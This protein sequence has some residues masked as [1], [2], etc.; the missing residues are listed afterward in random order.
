MKPYHATTP[1][2]GQHWPEQNGIY[3]GIARGFD[4]EPDGH[5]VLLDDMPPKKRMTWKRGMAWAVGLGNGAR[6]P[7]QFE[8]ALI[9][10]NIND[11][12]NPEGFYWSASEYSADSAWNQYLNSSYTSDQNGSVKTNACYVRAIR[13][14][15]VC[16]YDQQAMEL[17]EVCGWKAKMDG[18]PC[19][20]CQAPQIDKLQAAAQLG[21]DAFDK[22]VGR[23]PEFVEQAIAALR[24]ALK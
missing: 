24:Q 23:K 21:L 20:V 4:G 7:N 1:R 6:L 12:I 14:L 18:E 10:A 19:L 15:V 3:A 9:G 11:K 2:I 17:C 5:I 22:M 16:K 13:R 8:I